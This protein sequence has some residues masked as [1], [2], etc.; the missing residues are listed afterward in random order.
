MFINVAKHIH[1]S[2]FKKRRKRKK[3]TSAER[4]LQDGHR[5][6]QKPANK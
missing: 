3:E 4:K 1:R 2:L 5:R 6:G